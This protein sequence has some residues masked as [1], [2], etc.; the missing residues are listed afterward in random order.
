MPDEVTTPQLSDGVVVL[1]PLVR[2]DAEAHLAG[3]DGEQR[4]WFDFQRPST[5]EDVISFIALTQSEWQ[6]GGRQR[7]FAVRDA[8]TDLLV[9][10][11]ELRDRG[12]ARANI[13]V[14]VHPGSRRLGYATRAVRLAGEYAQDALPVQAV[15][16]IIDSENVAS[17]SV[18]ETAGFV[19]E[20]NAES[21]EYGESSGV[22]QRY[23]L[24]LHA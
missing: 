12:D 17:R 10:F 13:S 24:P 4:K 8:E 6:M 16:A 9:G 19:F 20:A 15:V 18:A 14:G 2:A 23:L 21:W 5:L 22:M 1:R 3:E 7:M 11:V